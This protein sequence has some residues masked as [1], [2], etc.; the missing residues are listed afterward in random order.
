MS[1][2]HGGPATC[3][4]PAHSS[5]ARVAA[6]AVGLPGGALVVLPQALPCW[7]ADRMR[8]TTRLQER[9]TRRGRSCTI[10]AMLSVR[11]GTRTW[12][13]G[14]RAAAAGQTEPA[15][16]VRARG[17]DEAR[18]L[19][20]TSG[21]CVCCSTASNAAWTRENSRVRSATWAAARLRLCALAS[22]WREAHKLL[23]RVAP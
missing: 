5:C 13:W 4:P 8:T 22:S 19:R 16:R 23:I 7:A 21:G 1:R 18:A 2:F 6:P 14:L 12:C 9:A 17:D 3:L 20:H 11:T 10:D 15:T